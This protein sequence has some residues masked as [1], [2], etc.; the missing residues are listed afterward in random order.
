M[1]QGEGLGVVVL[2]SYPRN[3]DQTV[4]H[5]AR[6]FIALGP[7]R[8]FVGVLGFGAFCD[9]VGPMRHFGVSLL[10]RY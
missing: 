3:F 1:R 8:A 6:S 9:C 2:G 7:C 5:S 4:G 10:N